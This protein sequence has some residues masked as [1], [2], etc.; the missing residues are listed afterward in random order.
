MRGLIGQRTPNNIC[1]ISL[2]VKHDLAMVESPVRV[3]YI[4]PFRLGVFLSEQNVESHFNPMGYCFVGNLKTPF[5][6]YKKFC[7]NIFTKTKGNKN[8][9][10]LI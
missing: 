4:A 10:V 9:W 5:A 8:L 1:S 6:F 3:W 7:Y 2:E